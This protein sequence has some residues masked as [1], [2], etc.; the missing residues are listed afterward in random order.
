MLPPVPCWPKLSQGIKRRH[1]RTRTEK[2]FFQVAQAK[3]RGF[4]TDPNCP[5][6]LIWLSIHSTPSLPHHL[7]CTRFP[8]NRTFVPDLSWSTPTVH[9]PSLP[10]PIYPSD[11]N[12]PNSSQARPLPNHIKHHTVQ[13]NAAQSKQSPSS[14]LGTVNDGFDGFFCD[15]RDWT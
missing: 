4:I 12:Q 3:I 15:T 14:V 10:T 7:S 13:S 2:S 8:S 6:G 5:S 11:L 1:T 9:A